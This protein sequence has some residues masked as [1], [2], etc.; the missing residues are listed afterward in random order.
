MFA[1]KAPR[2]QALPTTWHPERP[3]SSPYSPNIAPKQDRELGCSQ[4][5]NTVMRDMH[6]HLEKLRVQIAECEMIR[7]LASDPGKRELFRRL[8]EHH[9]VL[10]MEIE[11]AI[12][13]N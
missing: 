2:A 12:D 7:D 1:A 3:K 5:R 10:A 6:K 4:Q 9:K 11:K 13:E 8:A